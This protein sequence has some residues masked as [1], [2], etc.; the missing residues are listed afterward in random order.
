MY[1]F[2]FATEG[3][4]S[5]IAIA[6]VSLLAFFLLP[7]FGRKKHNLSENYYMI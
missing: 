6:S 3:I 7:L 5:I 1:V 2:S 4:S